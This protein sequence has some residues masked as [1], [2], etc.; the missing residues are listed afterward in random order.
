MSRPLAPQTPSL[1]WRITSSTIMGLTGLISRGFL[2]GLNSVE[3]IGLDKFLALLDS[4]RDPEKRER[5]LLTV[6]NHVSV[7][8]DPLIWGVLPPRYAFTPSNL[9]FG[10]GAHDICFKNPLLTSFFTYGQ[11]LPAHRTKHSP[12][13]GGLFQ[14]SL[15]EAIRLLSAP[16]PSTATLTYPPAALAPS[17]LAARNRHA[18]IHVFP[19]GLVHQH[20]AADLRYFKWGVA[21]LILEAEPAPDVLPMFIDGTQRLMPEHRTFPR[22]LPRVGQDVRVA[23]GDVVDFEKTFGDLRRRWQGLVARNPEKG[24]VVGELRGEELRVGEEAREIR[25][26]VA[27]RVREEVLK[28]RRSMGGFGEPEEGLGD[29]RAWAA[30]GTGKGKRYR[31]G[32]DGSD[33]NQD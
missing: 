20:P 24:G 13:H 16:P 12:Q 7:L 9:R 6:S 1:P 21:R 30:E 15:N 11:V 5:G 29:A 18:W 31:S 28:V 25:R 4:R 10:L 14:P 17:S 2:L 19:E 33:I 27:R 26:E 8:D 3:V 32:V 23:F 22:F